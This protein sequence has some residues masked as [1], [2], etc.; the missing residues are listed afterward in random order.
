MVCGIAWTIIETHY[1]SCV[2]RLYVVFIE[3]GFVFRLEVKSFKNMKHEPRLRNTMTAF[4]SS[5]Y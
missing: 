3:F 2:I 1:Y 5:L 4:H